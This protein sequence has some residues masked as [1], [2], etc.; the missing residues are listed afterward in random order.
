M[1]HLIEQRPFFYFTFIFNVIP[2]LIWLLR[3]PLSD[4]MVETFALRYRPAILDKV[5]PF[6]TR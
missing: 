5:S 6:F 3:S 4:L 2:G 1:A